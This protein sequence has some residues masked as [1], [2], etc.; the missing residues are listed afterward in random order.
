MIA[1]EIARTGE[2]D[3]VYQV[4]RS[5]VRHKRN[6]LCPTL[7]ANMGIGGHNVPFVR[8]QW[9]IRR[10]TVTECASLQ[11]FAESSIF[12]ASVGASSRYQMIGNAVTEAVASELSRGVGSV[13]SRI[14]SGRKG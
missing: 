13:I 6:G 9:G 11:G 2:R 14:P 3:D 5:Y 1:E 7:T 4:R 8:D 10:L 12:P